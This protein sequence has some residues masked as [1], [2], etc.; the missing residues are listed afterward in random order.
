MKTALRMGLA[1]GLLA[2]AGLST[3]AIGPGE[4]DERINGFHRDYGTFGNYD[5]DDFAWGYGPYDYYAIYR[6]W[7]KGRSYRP[8][9]YGEGDFYED[10]YGIFNGEDLNGDRYGIGEGRS[11]YDGDDDVSFHGSLSDGENYYTDDWYKY[12]DS[13]TD[14]YDALH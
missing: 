3:H 1:A 12:D 14:W 9:V 2:A 6:D 4:R 5:L 10:E 13:F 11:L 8:D 7:E